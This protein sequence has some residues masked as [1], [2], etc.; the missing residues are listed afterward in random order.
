MCKLIDSDINAQLTFRDFS[1]MRFFR[2]QTWKDMKE[3]IVDMRIE[4]LIDGTLSKSMNEIIDHLKIYLKIQFSNDLSTDK[5]HKDPFYNTH[6]LL[7]KMDDDRFQINESNEQSIIL[8]R[9]AHST[10][11]GGG[12]GSV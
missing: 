10:V 6:V 8:N 7:S 4:N 11:W 9:T 12:G 2:Y 1:S 3:L 5:N